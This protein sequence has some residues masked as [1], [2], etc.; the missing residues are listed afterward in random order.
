MKMKNLSFW[1]T[2]TILSLLMIT[3]ASAMVLVIYDYQKI[4]IIGAFFTC[5]LLLIL[6]LFTALLTYEVFQDRKSEKE[7]KNLLKQLKDENQELS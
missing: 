6:F 4:S 2:I 1:V 5:L 3:A 7:L